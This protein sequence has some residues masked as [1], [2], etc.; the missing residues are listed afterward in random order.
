MHSTLATLSQRR[1]TRQQP[2]GETALATIERE[3]APM[4]GP[5]I[6]VAT[7]DCYGTLVDWEGGVGSFLYQL[8]LRNGDAD[9]EPGWALRDRWEALQFDLLSGPYRPYKEILAESL[10]RWVGER[11]YPWDEADGAALVAAMRSWQ[12][13]PDT[14][15]ALLQT[16][17][18]GLRLV[19]VSNTDR[20]IVEH[21]LRHLA[22]PFD[23]VVTAEDCRAYKPSRA[24]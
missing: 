22:V 21:T 12:P 14:R 2:G 17:A 23:D 3:G 4:A 11:G 9:L 18:R 20:D 16:R 6:R 7:F 5:D 24:V 15:A 19:I 10:R 13:F 8:A 1:P